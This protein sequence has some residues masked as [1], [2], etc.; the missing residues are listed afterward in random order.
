MHIFE[1]HRHRQH[2]HTAFPWMLALLLLLL[3]LRY[4]SGDNQSASSQPTAMQHLITAN[5]EI[6]DTVMASCM[7]NGLPHDPWMIHFHNS[8]QEETKQ[9]DL[10]CVEWNWFFYHYYFLSF[11]TCPVDE[12]VLLPSRGSFERFFY[13]YGHFLFFY[14]FMF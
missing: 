9:S 3:L 1:M 13:F 8:K 12:G 2:T 11:H 5:V 6:I 10:M 14:L 4:L 7:H